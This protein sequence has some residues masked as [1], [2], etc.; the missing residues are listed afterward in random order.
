MFKQKRTVR[1]ASVGCC[2]SNWAPSQQYGAFP[3][4]PGAQANCG[5]DQTLQ[6]TPVIADELLLGV[7]FPGNFS[8]FV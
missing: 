6:V 1:L 2:K 5:Y 4:L 7:E 8:R 3:E